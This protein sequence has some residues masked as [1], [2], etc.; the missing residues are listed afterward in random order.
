MTVRIVRTEQVF[1]R[2][3]TDPE[4]DLVKKFRAALGEVASK[5][6]GRVLGYELQGDTLRISFA[7][8]D[9]ADKVRDVLKK[10]NVDME[11]VSLMDEFF[12]EVGTTTS[13]A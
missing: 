9:I 13:A 1:K 10:K 4:N 12:T 11:E 6:G 8:K 2:R 5:F 3:I 7:G